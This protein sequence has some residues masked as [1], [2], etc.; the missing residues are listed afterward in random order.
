MT[1][2]SNSRLSVLQQLFEGSLQPDGA[3]ELC[4][5]FN[6]WLASATQGRRDP[7]G[8]L[9]RSRPISLAACLRLQESPERARLALRDEYLRA[10]SRTLDCGENG[11]ARLFREA[12]VFACR[13]WPCWVGLTEPPAYASDLQRLLFYAMK[14]GGGRLPASKRQFIN[15]LAE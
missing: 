3:E 11:A 8:R 12:G 2:Q 7:D 9:L 6:T 5:A 4:R 14:A 1:A 10:A 13:Q 15:I